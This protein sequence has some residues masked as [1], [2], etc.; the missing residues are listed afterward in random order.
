[1][2]RSPITRKT[3]LRKR[4]PKRA[5]Y[6]RSAER[7]D[8]V[9]HMLAVKSLGCLVC[10]AHPAEAHHMPDPRSDW[11]VAPLCARHHRREYGPG[12]WHY[13]PR[14]FRELHGDDESLLQRVSD[15]LALHSLEITQR[16][17]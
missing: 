14:A 16:P 3:P 15:M 10:G 7:Q 4:S 1:M 12:A 2:K 11:R 9:A 8:A 13:S 6:M 17:D 5:A